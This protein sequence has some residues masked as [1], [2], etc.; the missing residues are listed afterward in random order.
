MSATEAFLRFDFKRRPDNT[1]NEE[2]RRR[3]APA[4][5]VDSAIHQSGFGV[6]GYRSRMFRDRKGRT[7]A[8]AAIPRSD[9]KGTLYMYEIIV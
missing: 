8:A 4:L 2:F 7:T 5:G 6:P 3:F 9:R 1:M